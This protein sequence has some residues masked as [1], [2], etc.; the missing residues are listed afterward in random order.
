[1]ESALRKTFDATMFNWTCL[2]NDAYKEKIPEPHVHWHFR[3]RYNH[4]VK[5]ADLTFEDMEFG[6]H[7]DKNNEKKISEDIKKIIVSKI[8]EQL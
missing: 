4:K 7:Y 8:K 5:V 3:P 2:M 6:H 1:L